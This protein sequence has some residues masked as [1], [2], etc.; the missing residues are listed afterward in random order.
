MR[1]DFARHMFSPVGGLSTLAIRGAI[2]RLHRAPAPT[3][4][5][6]ARTTAEAQHAQAPISVDL[7]ERSVDSR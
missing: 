6:S 7:F 3:Q 2:R 1:G 4:A 5:D